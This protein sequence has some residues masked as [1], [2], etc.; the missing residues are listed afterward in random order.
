MTTQTFHEAVEASFDNIAVQADG[1][2]EKAIVKPGVEGLHVFLEGRRADGAS[3]GVSAETVTVESLKKIFESRGWPFDKSFGRADLTALLESLGEAG[4]GGEDLAEDISSLVDDLHSRAAAKEFPLIRPIDLRADDEHNAAEEAMSLVE[5]LDAV[6]IQSYIDFQKKEYFKNSPGDPAASIDEKHAQ[7]AL[8][9]YYNHVRDFLAKQSLDARTCA[10][11]FA[12]STFIPLISPQSIGDGEKKAFARDAASA[13]RPELLELLDKNVWL[14]WDEMAEVVELSGAGAHDSFREL[15]EEDYF[16]IVRET[17]DAGAHQNAGTGLGGNAKRIFDIVDNSGLYFTCCAMKHNA[18]SQALRN[19]QDVAVYYGTGRAAIGNSKGM[20]YLLKVGVAFV[21]TRVQM[22]DFFTM[23]QVNIFTVVFVRELFPAEGPIH[24]H[25]AETHP[26]Q[27]M[28]SAIICLQEIPRWTAGKYLKRVRADGVVLPRSGELAGSLAVY[29]DS[30]GCL[31]EDEVRALACSTGGTVPPSPLLGPGA[32][33][34]WQNCAAPA[35]GACA[36]SDDD[37]MVVSTPSVTS[38]SAWSPLMSHVKSPPLCARSPPLACAQ[39]PG[40]FEE[41]S[42]PGAAVMACASFHE[43]QPSPEFS[44]LELPGPAIDMIE[45][46]GAEADWDLDEAGWPP[47]GSLGASWTAAAAAGGAGAA[48]SASG[49]GGGEAGPADAGAAPPRPWQRAVLLLFPLQ[50][51]LGRH[52]SEAHVDAV[53]RYFELASS[54]GAMGGRPRMAHF[55]VGRQ[56][57]ELLYVDPHVVQPAA[58]P[59]A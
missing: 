39:A 28:E 27:G 10:H 40:E 51:G 11:R 13:M 35:R 32:L 2:A 15:L 37:F 7:W 30:D 59:E 6:Q 38:A 21:G 25:A 22:T 33:A 4:S 53:L 34:A 46:E 54:L 26:E 48:R 45:E 55:F 52:A 8:N 57:R 18:E 12:Q 44:M 5:K 24:Q 58:L 31:Y 19:S 17:C 43:L 29:V 47:E 50:L 14:A 1:A 23:V 3:S 36:D 9:F 56:G 20:L 42:D 41:A 49:R 16:R